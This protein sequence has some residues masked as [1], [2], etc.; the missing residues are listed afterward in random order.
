VELFLSSVANE[1]FE[2]ELF[3]LIEGDFELFVDED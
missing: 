2:A 3:E 1:P